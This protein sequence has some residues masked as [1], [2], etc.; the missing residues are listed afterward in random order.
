M[1]MQ[2]MF[3]SRHSLFCMM[4]IL[5]SLACQHTPLMFFNRW[6]LVSLSLLKC[7]SGEYSFTIQPLFHKTLRTI[8]LLSVSSFIADSISRLQLSM[9]SVAL[10]RAD[11]GLQPFE[12]ATHLN[13]IKRFYDIFYQSLL[14]FILN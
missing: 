8:Y 10:K 4:A 5:L 12:D 7:H 9:Q 1:N 11:F 13:L 6:M 14:R 2:A 3:H